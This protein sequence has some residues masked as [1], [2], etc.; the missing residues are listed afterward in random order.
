MKPIITEHAEDLI[1]EQLQIITAA[2]YPEDAA[3][4]L[5][6]LYDRL[7]VLDGFPRAGQLSRFS[8][9]AKAGVHQLP[10]GPFIIYYT[11]DGETCE[12]VSIRR[13]AMDVRSPRGL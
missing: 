9:L 7:A 12:I 10:Y 4:W 6:G 11:I 2:Q 3:K 13:A 1:R 8:A 5:Q